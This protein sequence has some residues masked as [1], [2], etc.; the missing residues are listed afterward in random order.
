MGVDTSDPAA[1]LH[2][3]WEE[4]WRRMLPACVVSTQGDG[5]WFWVHVPDGAP[6]EVWVELEGGGRRDDV[7]QVAHWV[8][9]REV[10]GEYVGEATFVVPLDL[11]LGYHTVRA[12]SGDTEASAPLLVT[13]RWLGLPERLDGRAGWGFAAQLYSVPFTRLVGRRRPRRPHRPR[14]SGPPASAPTTC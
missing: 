11:P 7:S 2:A 5:Q 12:R 8:P 13:P 1:A 9:S 14:R 10:D 3:R 4:P 6:V